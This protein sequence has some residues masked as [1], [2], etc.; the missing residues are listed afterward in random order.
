MNSQLDYAQIVRRA[1]PGIRSVT[2]AV[3]VSTAFT[4]F[5]HHPCL[6]GLICG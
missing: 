6:S 5:F 4:T 2:A 3:G 1:Y